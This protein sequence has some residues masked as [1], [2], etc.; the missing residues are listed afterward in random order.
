MSL[1]KNKRKLLTYLSPPSLPLARPPPQLT[2]PNWKVVRTRMKSKYKFFEWGTNI[3]EE[4][5]EEVEKG[6]EDGNKD[7]KEDGKED[8]R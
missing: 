8:G 5:N 4:V 1:K 3:F 7:G 2:P 6:K